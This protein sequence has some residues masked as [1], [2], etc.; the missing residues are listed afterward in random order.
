MDLDLYA[1]LAKLN[2]ADWA[3]SFISEGWQGEKL[4]ELSRENLADL[5]IP[6]ERRG[7]VM[8]SVEALLEL[9]MPT[10]FSR[11][12]GSPPP[13]TLKPRFG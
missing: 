11:P 8:L 7:A 2:L 1:W 5:G 9:A 6:K 12:G 3:E 10:T 13:G 4:L